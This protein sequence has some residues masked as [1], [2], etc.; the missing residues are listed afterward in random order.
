VQQ[1]LGVRG[2]MW[3]GWVQLRQLFAFWRPR[4]PILFRVEKIM[5]LISQ[6]LRRFLLALVFRV[7]IRAAFAAPSEGFVAS[8]PQ[9]P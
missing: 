6:E 3:E 1:K 8:E 5:L 9:A 4:P 7:E 2:P